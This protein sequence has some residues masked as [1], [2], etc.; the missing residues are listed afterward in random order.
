MIKKSLLVTL[1]DKNYI[2]QAKQLFS[3]VYFNAGWQGDYML[4]AHD[5]PDKDLQWFLDKGILVKKC[6]PVFNENFGFKNVKSPTLLSKF[7]LF[8]LEFKKWKNVVFLDADIIVRKSL[9]KLAEINGFA[10]AKATVPLFEEFDFTKNLEIKKKL[11]TIYNFKTKAFNSGVMAFSTDVIK[12]KSFEELVKI[13]YSYRLVYRYGDETTFNLYFYR[14]WQEISFIYNLDP[15]FI[16]PRP[17][18]SKEIHNLPGVIL[19]FFGGFKPWYLSSIFYKEW[20]NNLNRADDIDLENRILPQLLISKEVEEY[21]LQIKRKKIIY[22]PIKKIDELVYLYCAPL[23]KFNNRYPKTYYL[24]TERKPIG[25]HQPDKDIQY[26]FTDASQK[27]P[28]LLVT[29]ADK[30]YIDQAKQLFSSVYFNAGWQGD[31]MLLAHDIPDKD[32]QWFLDKGILVKKCKPLFDRNFG[33]ENKKSP[34]ML[35]KFYL[36]TPEFKKWRNIVYLDTDIIVRKSLEGLTDIS[37]FAAAWAQPLSEEFKLGKES[38]TVKDLL[39]KYSLN[40]EAFNTG[41]MAFSTDIIRDDSFKELMELF[42][43]Y[44]DIQRN[45]D[46][47]T[48]N[49][50]FYGKWKEIPRL[51]YN[52][53]PFYLF[54]N[55]VRFKKIRN[56]PVAIFHFFD[57][58]NFNI[59]PWDFD[60]T[61]IFYEEWK[62]NLD[63]SDSINLK[64]RVVVK[65]LK[66]D[67]LQRYIKHI[68]I[69]VIV[70]HKIQKVDRLI[71]QLSLFVKSKFFKVHN[72][73]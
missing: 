69:K 62:N 45:G 28:S 27:N 46:E 65:E 30:N 71:G 32:L 70:Y 24:L 64:K 14:K 22:Y 43:K 1:A 36:F 67:E 49:L 12:E 68:G 47:P 2:D 16:I 56:L 8:S 50:F 63:K 51:I 21:S 54:S 9:E 20:K 52:F 3:S 73:N 57:N 5:I 26:T 55:I 58:R 33:L 42:H 44:R 59:K 13:F 38:D 53:S 72:L 7:Y 37:G 11:F 23:R 4:L 61:N 29:L 34:V 40:R 17:L 18:Q 48:L 39:R 60:P 19:H 6:K 25:I 10:A 31:Y 35:D 15:Y 41:V 66:E